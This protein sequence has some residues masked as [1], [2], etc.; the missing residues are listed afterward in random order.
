[1][2][3]CLVSQIITGKCQHLPVPHETPACHCEAGI[4]ASFGKCSPFPFKVHLCQQGCHVG[5]S[6]RSAGR[7][8][9]LAATAVG[10]RGGTAVSWHPQRILP[11]L[12]RGH[13][14]RRHP[15]QLRLHE[16][17]LRSKASACKCCSSALHLSCKHLGSS[18]SL[19]CNDEISHAHPAVRTGSG[20]H[21]DERATQPPATGSEPSPTDMKATFSLSTWHEEHLLA[22]CLAMLPAQHKGSSGAIDAISARSPVTAQARQGE[23]HIFLVCHG[24]V[25]HGR[26][27]QFNSL[28]HSFDGCTDPRN[29]LQEFVGAEKGLKV[30]R[31]CGLQPEMSPSYHVP[32]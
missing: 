5:I 25:M 16:F 24:R 8:C 26:A 20:C 32:R 21:Q 9:S 19:G 30:Q 12:S 31:Q 11:G 1:M 15:F 4:S 13:A 18:D 28:R 22:G 27:C 6:A 3:T 17:L 14:F 2:D 10:L 23:H 29:A 7:V